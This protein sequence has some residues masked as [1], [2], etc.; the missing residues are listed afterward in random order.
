M[1]PTGFEIDIEGNCVT[2]DEATVQAILADRRQYAR[3]PMTYLPGLLFYEGRKY[4]VFIRDISLSGALVLG[5]MPALPMDSAVRLEIWLQ[6]TGRLDAMCKIVR[7][8]TDPDV[9]GF[10][11]QFLDLTADQSRCLLRFLADA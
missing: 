9:V 11:V 4:L 3:I 6:N 1:K 2:A 5:N 10:G 7:R 8:H